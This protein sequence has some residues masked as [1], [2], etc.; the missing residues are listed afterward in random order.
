MTFAFDYVQDEKEAL[1]Y[2]TVGGDQS[3]VHGELQKALADALLG[4]HLGISTPSDRV[5]AH[6]FPNSL[7]TKPEYIFNHS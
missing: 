1:T 4:V 5:L 3:K 2:D 7:A 6:Q